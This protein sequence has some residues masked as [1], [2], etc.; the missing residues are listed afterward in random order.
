[1]FVHDWSLFPRGGE[2]A[3]VGGTL[4]ADNGCVLL[5]GNDRGHPVVWPA[6]TSIAREDPLAV[7]LPSGQELAVGQRVAGSGGAHPPSSQRVGVKIP[8]KCLPE[9]DGM[10]ADHVIVFNPDASLRIAE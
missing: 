1:M 4:T 8:A 3:G 9:A 7:E 6:G 10:D 5:N 2:D